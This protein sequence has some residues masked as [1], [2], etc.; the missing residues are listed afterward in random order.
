MIF[1]IILAAG[2]QNIPAAK[3]TINFPPT[4]GTESNLIDPIVL[5][6]K[7]CMLDVW[8]QTRREMMSM[9]IQYDRTRSNLYV[10]IMPEHKGPS[11]GKVVWGNVFYS[12]LNGGPPTARKVK[13]TNEGFRFVVEGVSTADL[14]V[15][16]TSAKITFEAPAMLGVSISD[17]SI[18]RASKALQMCVPSKR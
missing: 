8:V 10:D 5:R 3:G 6:P 1:S 12:P 17:K 7:Y 18:G 15:M 16:A 9:N 2:I 4:S 14:S 13:F 11:I